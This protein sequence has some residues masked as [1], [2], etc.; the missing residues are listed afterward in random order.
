VKLN[1]SEIKKITYVVLTSSRKLK[2]YFQSHE[3]MVPTSQPLGDILKNKEASDR[4]GKWATEL[5]QF[6]ISYVPRTAIK[7]QALADFMVDWTPPAQ[8]NP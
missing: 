2:H 1:Y 3:I 4:I 7:S 5:S 8:N 6:E